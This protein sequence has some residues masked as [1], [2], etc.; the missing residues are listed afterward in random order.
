MQ[1]PA[2]QAIFCNSS[3]N[4][5]LPSKEPCEKLLLWKYLCSLLAT[6]CLA[7]RDKI[8]I[9]AAYDDI[10]NRDGFGFAN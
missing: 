6:Y 7:W 5:T 1:Y 4:E 2:C 8:E 3:Y 10:K 9:L